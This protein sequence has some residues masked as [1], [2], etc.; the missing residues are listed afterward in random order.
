MSDLRNAIFEADD[1]PETSFEVAEWGVTLLIRGMTG[2][3]RAGM[4]QRSVDPETGEMLMEALYPEVIIATAY[5]PETKQ[6]VF[7]ESDRNALNLKSG[8]I[9]E[10]VAREGMRLSGLT[11]D[12]Q[13]EMGK[14]SSLA[15]EG[16]TSDS[17]PTSE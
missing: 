17:P 4:M 2:A 1:V 11:S 5:D 15:N 14:D 12:E 6:P 9:L 10:R 7:V 3:A 8:G 16:S 13:K